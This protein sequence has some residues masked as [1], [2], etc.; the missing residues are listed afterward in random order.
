MKKTIV[1]PLAITA[2]ALGMLWGAIGLAEAG[3]TPVRQGDMILQV[4]I[5]QYL[6]A[7]TKAGFLAMV[8]I[9][10]IEDPNSPGEMI[11]RYTAK[12]HMKLWLDYQFNRAVDE[13]NRRRE[14][15]TPRFVRD[16]NS[17]Q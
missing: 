17:T 11:P 9:P 12:R 5:P 4:R 6:V 2:L 10:M 15:R 8:P 3:R 13:G 14:L 16:P 7:E 1:I